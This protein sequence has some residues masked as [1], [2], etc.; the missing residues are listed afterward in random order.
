MVKTEEQEKID[1]FVAD[2]EELQRK[3]GV[4]I[5]PHVLIGPDKDGFLKVE[6]RFVLVEDK[7]NITL[8]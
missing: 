3:H 7:P 4:K 5:Q 8:V 6:Q 1:N 2:L